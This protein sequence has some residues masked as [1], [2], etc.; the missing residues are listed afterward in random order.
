VIKIEGLDT[1]RL[2]KVSG[3]GRDRLG[4]IYKL[5]SLINAN[6][7]NIL[8]QRSMQVAGD[9]AVIIVAAY[10]EE[11]TAGVTNTMS[12]LHPGAIGDDFVTL[13]REISFDNA[14]IATEEGKKVLVKISGLDRQ[15]I[16]DSI[17]LLLL[18]HNLNVEFMESEVSH[19]PFSGTIRFSG[20]FG[21]TIPL[22]FNLDIFRSEIYEF[23]QLNNLEAFVE[24]Q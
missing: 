1:A 15:G 24:E 11:N 6:G 12:S 18:Q 10:D 17:S 7:G 16:V 19:E 23:E 2:L 22:D 4:I 20:L 21:T 14:A 9:F 8:L 5:A 13:V 3:I